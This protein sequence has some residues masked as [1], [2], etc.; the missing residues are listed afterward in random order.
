MENK[1]KPLVVF[2]GNG[3][4]MIA[5]TADYKDPTEL[6]NKIALTSEPMEVIIEGWNANLMQP[7]SI[8]VIKKVIKILFFIERALVTRTYSVYMEDGEL[9][10]D[11]KLKED[12]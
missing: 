4:L 2:R 6:M 1:K 8:A 9:V 11:R 7:W 5:S 3:K 10:I 12:K